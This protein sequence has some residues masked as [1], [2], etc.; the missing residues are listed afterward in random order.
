MLAGLPYVVWPVGSLFILASRKKDDPYLYYHAVQGALFG[1]AMLVLSIASFIGLGIVFRL[2]PGSS[3][4]LPGMLGMATLAGGGMVLMAIFLTAIFLAWRAT[5]GEMLRLPFAGDFA[6]DKMLD[7]TGMTRRQFEEM[8]EQSFVEP[9][10]D[11]P[12]PIPFPEYGTPALTG[13]AAE[14]MAT[15]SAET[16]TPA[17]LKA[18]EILAHRQA[19]QA[20]A[21]KAQAAAQAALATQQQAAS[22]AAQQAAALQAAQRPLAPQAPRQQQPATP[23]PAAP[24]PR[25]AAPQQQQQ[26]QRAN[27]PGSTPAVR[28]AAAPAASSDSRAKAY[29]LIR[30]TAESTP[31]VKEVDLIRHYKERR[32]APP[33]SDALRNWLSAVD[34]Q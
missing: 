6:E 27:G 28:P 2:L 16:A 32:S 1:A 12:E 9:A 24:A 5:E 26:Q 33:Q 34:E 8:L 29:P 4:Y 20:A 25:P 13:K 22:L 17:S 15:R 11:E 14:V 19:Q 21:E 10:A 3:T 30:E 7:H 23:R 18:A 31:Q